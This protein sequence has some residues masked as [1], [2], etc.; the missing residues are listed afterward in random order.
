MTLAGLLYLGAAIGVLPLAV[1]RPV[2]GQGADAANV[3][4]LIG[5]V[6]LG[7]CVAPVFLLVGLARAPAASVALWL[8]MEVVA[9]TILAWLFFR[10]HLDL[11]TVV[12]VGGVLIAS[13]LLAAP[14]GLGAASAALA[15]AVACVCWGVDNNLTSLI[16]GFTPAQY[17]LVKGVVAGLWNLAL[18]VA[19]ERPVLEWRI[20]LP[21]LAVGAV[22]YGLSLVLYVSG[23]QQL[24]AARSQMLFAASP[25]LGTVLCWAVLG[26]PVGALQVVA[27]CVMLISIG[28]LVSARHGHPHAHG[29]TVHTHSHR[30]D[31]GHH[32]HAHPGLPADT[33]HTHPHVHEPIIHAHVHASDLHH[34]H[35]H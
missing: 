3:F 29:K 16:D 20:A 32:A 8:N 21:A 34:R 28:T 25:F 10:E 24:G 7:G 23:A 27:G 26:E 9:T 11:R 4:R 1:S 13:T 30:H 31:D 18:G 15:V 2:S 14:S 35:G 5:A 12:A 6:A 19:R 33:Q 22:A 17:T